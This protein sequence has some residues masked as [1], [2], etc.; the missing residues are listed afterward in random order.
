MHPPRKAEMYNLRQPVKQVYSELAAQLT[1]R[2]MFSASPHSNASASTL[3][4]LRVPGRLPAGLPDR[5]GTK[6]PLASRVMLVSP[7]SMIEPSRFRN[8]A[9]INQN[10]VQYNHIRPK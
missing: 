8:G 3:A 7:P 10:N 1:T 5:P 9:N 6:R 2:A 4:R